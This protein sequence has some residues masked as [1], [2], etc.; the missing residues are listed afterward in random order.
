MTKVLF[1]Y[2]KVNAERCRSNKGEN[3]VGSVEFLMSSIDGFVGRFIGDEN[4]YNL[5]FIS[6][7]NMFRLCINEYP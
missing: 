1:T 5:F 7:S 2:K 3:V 4:T 6:N